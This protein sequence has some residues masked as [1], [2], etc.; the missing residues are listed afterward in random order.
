MLNSQGPKPVN[1]NLF[2]VRLTLDVI[3]NFKNRSFWII[4]AEPKSGD[5]CPSKNTQRELQRRKKKM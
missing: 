3:K 5:N 2:G 4:Q 1:M